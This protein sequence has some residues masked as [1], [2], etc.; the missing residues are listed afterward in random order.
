MLKFSFLKKTPTP[1]DPL[2]VGD[3][4]HSRLDERRMTIP[5]YLTVN[6]ISHYRVLIEHGN[7]RKFKLLSSYAI[8]YFRYRLTTAS[9]KPDREECQQSYHADGT[10]TQD[11][12]TGA[13]R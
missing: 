11:D 9:N 8:G 3:I 5:E 13:Y 12:Y 10:D 6:G 1:T 4:L 7:N 2:Q